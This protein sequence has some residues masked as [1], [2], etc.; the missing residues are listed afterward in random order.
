MGVVPIRLT[1]YFIQIHELIFFIQSIHM[2]S[3]VFC[4][5]YHLKKKKAR[6]SVIDIRLSNNQTFT[7][8]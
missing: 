6:Y 5:N 7:L 2:K 3:N 4:S 1:K 8:E